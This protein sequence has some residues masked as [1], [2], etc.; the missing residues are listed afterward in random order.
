MIMVKQQPARK[1][2]I[3]VRGQQMIIDARLMEEKIKYVLRST[4][5]MPAAKNCYE[6]DGD[7]AGADKIEGC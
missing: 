2:V 1:V 7:G 4:L 5:C 6:G 3:E